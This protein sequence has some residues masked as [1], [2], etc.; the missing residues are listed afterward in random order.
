MSQ[1]P[2]EEI[3]S[4]FYPYHSYSRNYHCLH[5]IQVSSQVIS[6]CIA[7]WRLVFMPSLLFCYDFIIDLFVVWVSFSVCRGATRKTK[8]CLD[9]IYQYLVSGLKIHGS[10]KRFFKNIDAGIGSSYFKSRPNFFIYS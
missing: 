9:R 2:G 8:V 1:P 3:S 6:S 5:W 7:Q 4:S 10:A